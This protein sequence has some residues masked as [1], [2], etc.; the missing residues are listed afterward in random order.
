E[1]VGGEAFCVDGVAEQDQNSFAVATNPGT[2]GLSLIA[3]LCMPAV[4]AAVALDCAPYATPA[5]AA[6][7]VSM[8]AYSTP[9]NSADPTINTVKT[10]T[11]KA[12]SIIDPPVLPRSRAQ[13]S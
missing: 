13:R 2:F 6:L 9:A 7:E 4:S 1:Q 3:A 11:I 8:A 12:I 5:R 10:G